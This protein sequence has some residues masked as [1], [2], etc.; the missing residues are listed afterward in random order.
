MNKFLSLG[1]KKAV[2]EGKE[3]QHMGTVSSDADSF[4]VCEM[5]CEK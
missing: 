3:G 2:R 4:S 1:R 5:P